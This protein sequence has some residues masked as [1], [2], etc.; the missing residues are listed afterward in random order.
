MHKLN[1]LTRKQIGKVINE[2]FIQEFFSDLW[3]PGVLQSMGLQ[4]VG[5]DWGTELNWTELN[6]TGSLEDF[7]EFSHILVCLHL[8][9]VAH[10]GCK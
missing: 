1:E 7:S 2:M 9:R 3:R 10:A 5:Y 8:S 4:R 6:W